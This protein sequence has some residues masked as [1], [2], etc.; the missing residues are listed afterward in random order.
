M[1]CGGSKNTQ[2]VSASAMGDSTENKTTENTNTSDNGNERNTTEIENKLN[3]TDDNKKEY[4]NTANESE[5]I[6]TYKIVLVG[7]ERV[8]KTCVSTRFV[9]DDFIDMYLPTLGPES[10]TKSLMIE[11]KAVKLQILDTSGN[12]RFVK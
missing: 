3:Q 7:D 10:K 1:G 11:G 2:S 4:E 6:K 8:G 9:R 5:T 12:E